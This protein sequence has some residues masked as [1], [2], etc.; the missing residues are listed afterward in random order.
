MFKSSCFPPNRHLYNL[1]ISR[2]GNFF[3]HSF[4]KLFTI[5]RS[6]ST[7]HP[8]DY[9]YHTH[10]G[11]LTARILFTSSK[12]PFLSACTLGGSSR[13]H[14]ISAE[15]WRMKFS[16]SANIDVSM[17]K[18]P[19]EMVTNEFVL[20]SPAVFCK[21]WSSWM[22]REIWG[23][24]SYRCC[25]V[26]RYFHK[27]IIVLFIPS[28]IVSFESKRLKHSAKKVSFYVHS[29]TIRNIW[30]EDFLFY[31]NRKSRFPFGK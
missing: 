17:C 19:L 9:Q 1:S 26:G 13:R 11:L 10:Q 7:W 21:S 3:F 30:L 23:K 8:P 22:V 27:H 31:F 20:T 29:L 28:S 15:N 24:W 16:S 12:Y 5:I 25:F 2:P 14:Q 6:T 4:R 18:S